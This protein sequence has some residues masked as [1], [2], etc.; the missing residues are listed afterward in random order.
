MWRQIESISFD[1]KPLYP[2]DSY[3]TFVE[4]QKAKGLKK[5]YWQD[6]PKMW[7]EELEFRKEL[8][9]AINNYSTMSFKTQNL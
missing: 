4:L 3:E 2:S 1:M 7:A 8:E 6:L 5:K 9:E